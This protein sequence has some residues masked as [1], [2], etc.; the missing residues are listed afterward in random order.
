MAATPVVHTQ[1]NTFN[2]AWLLKAD[3]NRQ[4]F[5]DELFTTTFSQENVEKVITDLKELTNK[6]LSESRRLCEDD[7]TFSLQVNSFGWLQVPMH[8]TRM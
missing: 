6:K 2:R 1:R 7:F 5:A 3:K 4:P 8:L